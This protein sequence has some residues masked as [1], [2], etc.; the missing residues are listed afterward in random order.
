MRNKNSEKEVEYFPYLPYSQTEDNQRCK[1][2]LNRIA[3]D[4][5]T[6]HKKKNSLMNLLNINNQRDTNKNQELLFLQKSNDSD[7]NLFNDFMKK[8]SDTIDTNSRNYLNYITQGI[9]KV[10]RFNFHTS[11]KK[12]NRQKYRINYDSIK[13][14]INSNNNDFLTL[15]NNKLLNSDYIEIEKKR[16]FFSNKNNTTE[17]N[18][19]NNRNKPGYVQVNAKKRRTDITDPFYFKEIGEEITKLNND[20]MNYNITEAENKNKTKNIYSRN[21]R[22]EEEISISP[23]KIRNSNYYNLGESSLSINPILDKGSYFENEFQN[24]KFNHNRKK[25]SF[26]IY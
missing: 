10:N 2:M 7:I 1:Q 14:N 20:T 19:F 3:K 17:K 4:P 22:I 16:L 24:L 26:C 15:N 25:S 21:N 5:F 6:F 9:T 18:I 8:K 23:E 11:Q 12:N 13:E